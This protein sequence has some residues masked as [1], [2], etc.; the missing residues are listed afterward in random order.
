MIKQAIMMLGVV[1]ITVGV[2][3]CQTAQK[4]VAEQGAVQMGQEEVVELLSDNTEAWD[5]GAGFFAAD[6]TIEALWEGKVS[7]GTWRVTDEGKLCYEVKDWWAT[8]HCDWVYFRQDDGIT[9]VNTR[10]NI[11]F[12]KDPE[13]D[14]TAG[15][16][17]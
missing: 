13:T 4:Q 9:I 3:G 6:G 2:T 7:T 5:K 1:G 15:N 10:K 16:T 11:R 14:Y 17:I 12:T 8:E